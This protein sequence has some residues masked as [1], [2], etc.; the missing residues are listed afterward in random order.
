[1]LSPKASSIFNIACGLFMHRLIVAL[2]VGGSWLESGASAKN[3]CSVAACMKTILL[4]RVS[5][6][7]GWPFLMTPEQMLLCTEAE[8]L[9]AGLGTP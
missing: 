2:H 4:I 3:T 8:L 5:V 1:M 7:A 9:S 6:A